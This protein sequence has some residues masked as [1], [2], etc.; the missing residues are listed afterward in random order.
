MNSDLDRINKVAATG[1]PSS[2]TYGLNGEEKRLVPGRR[3]DVWDMVY[4]YKRELEAA[5]TSVRDW[6]VYVR[7]EFLG[8]SYWRRILGSYLN[9]E[10]HSGCQYLVLHKSLPRPRGQGTLFV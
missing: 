10:I 8:R 1:I 3:W 4:A 9:H 6:K 5:S 2:G 7:S